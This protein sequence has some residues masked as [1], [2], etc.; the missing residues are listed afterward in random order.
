M[1]QRLTRWLAWLTIVLGSGTL[2]QVPLTEPPGF[3][4]A[5]IP[6]GGCGSFYANGVV[7]GVDFCYLLNCDNGFI[8]GLVQPCGDPDNPDD[9]LLV[10]CSSGGGTTTT[11]DTTQQ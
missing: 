1:R 9:D 5:H 10:D 8:G 4:N 6:G 3:S 7:S 11:D 2:F